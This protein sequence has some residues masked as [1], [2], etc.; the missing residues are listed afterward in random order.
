MVEE[1]Q[2]HIAVGH[3]EWDRD[4]MLLNTPAGYVDL[5]SGI[6]YPS[7]REKM[8][9]KIT[10]TEF[11]DTTG[12]EQWLKF[13]DTTF[14][15]DKALIHEVQKMVGYSATASTVEQVMFILLGNGRN[16]KSVFMNT[17]AKALGNY[18]MTMQVSSIMT[19]RSQSGPTSDIARLENARLVISSEANEGDRLDESLLKQMTGGDKMVA[20]FMYGAD[21]EFVPKF[22]LWMATN[23]LP[24]IRGTDDGIWRRLI[25]VPF[26]HQV[27]IEEVDK[28]LE[29]KLDREQ[30]GILSWIVDGAIAWQSEGLTPTASMREMIKSYRKEMDII[31]RF[32]ADCCEVEEGATVRPGEFYQSYRRWALENGEHQY[33]SVKFG[34]EVQKRFEKK[35]VKGKRFY[36][37]VRLRKIEDPRT[38]FLN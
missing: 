38:G 18:A 31:E 23:H 1:V 28:N 8:F 21:F 17:I 35:T 27:P 19:K 14:Q 24:F 26:T 13:L 10:G 9:S 30:P 5:S 16:G 36:K 22:K 29:A 34:K 11:S 33:S 20:R 3:D 7:D 12:C 6:L 15:G 32:V 37:G 25:G 2:H 4:G